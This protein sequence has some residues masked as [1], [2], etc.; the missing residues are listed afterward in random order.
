MNKAT[1]E[2]IQ[3]VK[4]LGISDSDAW[5][6]RRISMTLHR[7]HEMECGDGGPYGSW[8]I[9]RGKKV[10]GAFEYD[11]TGKPFKE[12]HYNS[13]AKVAYHSVA[14]RETGALKRLRLIMAGYPALWSYVQ[15]D[16]RGASLYV[17]RHDDV[18]GRDLTT[19]YTNGVAI[20]K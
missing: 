17:G 11:D 8:T 18:K 14:D 13:S 12:I 16:P 19:C 5:S 1:F 3:R 4:A 9:A 15:G 10:D 2:M 20:Y 7:W 6:L